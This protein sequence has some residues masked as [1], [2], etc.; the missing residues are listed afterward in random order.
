MEQWI[1][2]AHKEEDKA[3]PPP[4]EAGQQEGHDSQPAA[5]EPGY[6]AGADEPA[7]PPYYH[8]ADVSAG[9]RAGRRVEGR[10]RPACLL[11][12][13]AWGEPGVH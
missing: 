7:E 9:G 2:G 3:V 10:R 13:G 11:C 5:G 12:S 4:A 8:P 6:D 1:P